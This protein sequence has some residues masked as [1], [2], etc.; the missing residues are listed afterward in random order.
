MPDYASH[1]AP[2]TNIELDFSDRSG[3]ALGRLKIK[4][5]TILWKPAGAKLYRSISLDQFSKWI[6]DPATGANKV[7]Y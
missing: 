4:P 3:A 1:F 5:S 6:L 7:N 2:S